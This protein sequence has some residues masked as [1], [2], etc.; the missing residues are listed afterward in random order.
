MKS[1]RCA[2]T[3]VELLVVV[4]I[5]ALLAAIL[6]PVFGRA[7]DN[8]RAASCKSNMKQIYTA[9]RVYA[10]DFD[11][12]YPSNASLGNSSFRYITDTMS[13]PALINP[14]TKSDQ[15]WNCPSQPEAYK[16][17]GMPGYWWAKNATQMRAPDAAEDGTNALNVLIWDNY[18]Y[19]LPSPLNV[20][21]TNTA[22]GPQQHTIP[23]T[24]ANYCAHVGNTNFNAL[25]FD[26]HVKLY[27]ARTA[28]TLCRVKAIP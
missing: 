4:A 27:P 24:S 23:N 17:A 28:Q 5:I 3:L 9:M 18:P 2:F 11:G 22:T 21:Q 6:F 14:Y 20:V 1:V 13:L 15:I 8:A 19:R 10:Q 12:S 16:E 7:R 26:G 25:W